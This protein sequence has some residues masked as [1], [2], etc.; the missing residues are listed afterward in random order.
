M[1]A[2]SPKK[3][4]EIAKKCKVSGAENRIRERLFASNY[5]CQP[6]ALLPGY[7]AFGQLLNLLT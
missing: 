1:L 5:D 2:M 6:A 4:Q 7:P 3:A